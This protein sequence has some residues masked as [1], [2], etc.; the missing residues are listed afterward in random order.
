M[1]YEVAGEQIDLTQ[2]EEQE[3]LRRR[4]STELFNDK[5][6]NKEKLREIIGEC[7][8]DIEFD[9]LGKKSGITVTVH[10]YIPTW[11]VWHG[12]N[13]REYDLLDEVMTDK[14]YSGASLENLA[15]NTEFWI[16]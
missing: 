5:I 10:N 12:E 16:I 13:I 14:F 6:M 1:I 9:Y 11:Q 8:H 4:K 2:D 3:I 15:A 7:C